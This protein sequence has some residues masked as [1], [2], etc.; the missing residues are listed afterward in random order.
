M[1]LLR[2]SWGRSSTEPLKSEILLL[3]GLL[4]GRKNKIICVQKKN[5]YTVHQLYS[6]I[7]TSCENLEVQVWNTFFGFQMILSSLS[8]DFESMNI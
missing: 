8:I 3:A 2:T 1:N 4:S 7:L 6:L 5:I